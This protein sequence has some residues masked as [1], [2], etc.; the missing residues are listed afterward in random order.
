[1]RTFG[2][3]NG[4]KMCRIIH[5]SKKKG[6]QVNINRRALYFLW[7][8]NWEAVTK[9]DEIHSFYMQRD[10]FPPSLTSDL[11]TLLALIW[12]INEGGET[13]SSFITGPT[14]SCHHNLLTGLKSPSQ[15]FTDCWFH[16]VTVTVWTQ[17]GGL[18]V[19]TRLHRRFSWI[20]AV[21]SWTPEPE[22]FSHSQTLLTP[23]D[24]FI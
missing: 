12:I 20:S 13:Y 22:V 18:I 8:R 1:M 10:F 21:L 3:Y 2:V 7:W 4:M 14:S 23:N 5:N 16:S 9:Y 11:A 24:V 19:H 15:I 17:H 6:I